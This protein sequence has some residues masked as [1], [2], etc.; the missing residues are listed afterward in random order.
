M[1]AADRRARDRFFRR[2]PHPADLLRPF[3]RVPGVLYF[4]KDAGCRIMAVSPESVP[5]M[6]GTAEDDVIG[7]AP[8]DY[9]PADIADKYLADD[10]RVLRTG[11]PL[12]D[13]VEVWFN[14]RKLRDWVATDKFPLRDR[15]G[16]VVGLVGTLRSLADRRRHAADLGAVGAAADYIRDRLGHPLLLA[17]IAAAAGYS[18]RHLERLFRRAFG[19][20]VRRFVIQSR[21]HAAA[22]ELTQTDRSVTDIAMSFGFC[23]PSAFGHAFRAVVGCPPTVYRG[24]YRS[25]PGGC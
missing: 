2:L 16:N 21:V 6:G 20:S 1:S 12:L 24:R 9:L 7:M 8:H 15:G 10:R 25:A 4:V 11:R 14:E 3:D 22:R 18:E 19:M 23:D 17:D 5:R 13:M